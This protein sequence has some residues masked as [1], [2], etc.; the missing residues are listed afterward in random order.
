MACGAQDGVHEV[1]DG[2]GT[3]TDGERGERSSPEGV[4][5]EELHD[6]QL[7]DDD[8]AHRV[9]ERRDQLDVVGGRRADQYVEHRDPQEQDHRGRAEEP[10]E[11]DGTGVV[12]G[13]RPGPA[14]DPDREQREGE[15]EPRF[16]EARDSRIV[17]LQCEDHVDGVTESPRERAEAE[18][19][20]GASELLV[21]PSSRG[22]RAGRGDERGGRLDDED[23]DLGRHGRHRVMGPRRPVSGGWDVSASRRG[24]GDGTRPTAPAGR[25]A[26]PCRG[27]SRGRGGSRPVGRRRRPRP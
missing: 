17:A 10:V 3:D 26:I 21:P 8:V 16:R 11:G 2:D 13:G 6:E 23:R 5:A 14:V 24:T 7:E 20:P 12:R 4:A 1:R 19:P 9:Q 22:E 27:G 15:Q 25:S 18:P